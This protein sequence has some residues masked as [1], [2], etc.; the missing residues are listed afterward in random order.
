M[1]IQD[2]TDIQNDAHA[3][4]VAWKPVES[5]SDY[6][7]TGVFINQ[8]QHEGGPY[9][10]RCAQQHRHSKHTVT[11]SSVH[12]G[13]SCR[14]ELLSV[15]LTCALLC[16]VQRP[17]AFCSRQMNAAADIYRDLDCDVTG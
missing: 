9:L 7:K 11:E 17:A 16:C 3:E 14:L 4:A 2:D 8:T 12:E 6:I 15:S 13:W 10:C 1:L 5:D